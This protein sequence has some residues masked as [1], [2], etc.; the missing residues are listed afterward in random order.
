M[1]A[2]AETVT[3][4]VQYL[5]PIDSDGLVAL[6]EKGKTNPDAVV[7]LKAKTVCEGQ[8]RMQ[9]YVRDLKP[10]LI[11]EPPHLLGENN[12][13]NPS[14]AVL[15]TLGA[16][17]AVGVHANAT[18][19]GVKLTRLELVLEGDINVTAVWGTGDL[20]PSKELG[21]TDVRVKVLA[22]G[23]APKS[24]IDEIISH[25]NVWSP[26]ANTLRRNVNLLVEPV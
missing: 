4:S 10:L 14:E 8:F 13:P 3:T 23:D 5:R 11:D 25:S 20:D 2:N 9:T 22:D 16:C 21:F 26:V 12:A 1:N 7:T 19:R 15:A 18:A 17:L 24:V 6:G